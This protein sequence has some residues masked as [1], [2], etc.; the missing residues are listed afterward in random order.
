MYS[1][2]AYG[3]G[4]HSELVLPE[5]MP[6]Q[7]EADVVVRLGKVDRPQSTLD[8]QVYCFWSTRRGMHIFWS[9]AGTFLIRGGR[10]I[11]VDPVRCVDEKHLRLILLGAAMGVALHQRGYLVLHSSAV[12]MNGG[13]V[14]FLGGKRRGKST[15]AAGLCARGHSFMADDVVA[16]Q[17]DSANGPTV[18]PG[19]PQL[20]LW[21]D[22]VASLGEDPEALPRVSSRTDKR[23][24]EASNGFSHDPA[25]LKQVFALSG[26]A[27]VE[28]KPLQPRQALMELLGNLYVG[29]FGS[30]LLRQDEAPR[31]LQCA[32]VV[33]SVPI[34]GLN[35]P[36]SSQ[37][38]PTIAQ[39]VERQLTSYNACRA[40]A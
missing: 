34:H 17:F 1:Y 27:E 12:R 25:P 21:P 14:L 40:T 5:L 22:A 24:R 32:Q 23:H 13:A 31:L 9:E 38:V 7:R 16:L 35:R 2:V 28:I 19:F 29:R 4:I 26:G 20:K 36:P 10:E 18:L 8:S 6:G 11:I 37:V 30:Q 15:I 33:R 39:L 3:L